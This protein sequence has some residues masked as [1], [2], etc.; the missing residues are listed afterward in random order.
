MRPAQLRL[1]EGFSSILVVHIFLLRTHYCLFST[2]LIIKTHVPRMNKDAVPSGSLIAMSL[3]S[4]SLLLRRVYLSAALTCLLFL[5]FSYLSEGC[6]NLQSGWWSSN[7]IYSAARESQS[8][9]KRDG[10][11]RC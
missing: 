9:R 6:R 1:I 11:H 7:S 10:D 5:L 3:S 8:D 4:P 2:P